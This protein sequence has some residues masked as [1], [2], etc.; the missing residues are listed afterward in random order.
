MML[1]LLQFFFCN[2]VHMTAHKCLEFLAW[3]IFYRVYLVADLHCI[4]Y[5]LSLIEL[6]VYIEYM[7]KDL[8]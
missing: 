2:N 4:A 1:S 5:S 6:Q 7:V 8:K 3:Y